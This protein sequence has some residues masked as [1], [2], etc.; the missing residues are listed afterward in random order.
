MASAVQL[1]KHRVD[2][3]HAVAAFHKPPVLHCRPG[4]G[5]TSREDRWR[6][7]VSSK[8]VSCFRKKSWIARWREDVVG[9]DGRVRRV[10]K[11]QVIG[12]LAG[13][14]T[15]KLAHRRLELLL[16][17]VNA[18]GYRPGRVATLQ[19][20]SERG[21]NEIPAQRKPSTIA[22]AEGH[23]KNHILPELGRLRLEDISVER[24]QSFATLL[25]RRMS[26]KT[27]FN[28]LGTLSAVLSTAV[29][30]GYWGEAV[31]R[32]KLAFPSGRERPRRRFF[33]AEEIRRIV[34]AAPEP[35]ATL[36]LTAALTG[37]RQGEPIGLTVTD[38]DFDHS[39]AVRL[40][41]HLQNWRPNPGAF[42]FASRAGTP[43]NPHHLV[44]RRLQPYSP[45]S[46]SNEQ[47]CSLFGTATAACS[48]NWAHRLQ[49]RRHKSGTVT[50][51]PQCG[52]IRT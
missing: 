9:L 12:T 44:A 4:N 15:K 35:C 50:A 8:V 43:L 33:T 16:A 25:S 18:I 51:R 26:R 48:L 30:W 41:Q 1:D 52:H 21:R 27:L 20:F 7:N 19:E 29:M 32:R 42:L 37:M 38:W 49:S 3:A 13:L 10:R 47:G 31:S 34:E 36:F 40:K 14:P 28:V 2:R 17:K 22:A 11:A 39:L 46:K 5:S 6:A 45:D 23:L 24:Q